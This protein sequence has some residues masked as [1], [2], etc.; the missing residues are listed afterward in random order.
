MLSIVAM[1]GDAKA[2]S[3]L[4]DALDG[5][6]NVTC[7]R[8]AAELAT[9]ATYAASDIV[10]LGIK[11]ATQPP[12][13]LT[14]REAIERRPA[15]RLF[16]AC[17]ADAADMRTLA[18]LRYLDVW[19]VVLPYCDSPPMTRRRLLDAAP[20]R[21]ADM[22]V[23]RIMCRHAPAWI[24]PLIEWCA[25]HDGIARPDVPSLATTCNM[26]RETLARLCHMRGVCPP[27]HIISWVLVVRAR[28]R[29]VTPRHTLA[30]IAHDLGLASA[31]SLANLIQRR[32]GQTATKVR[33]LTL[34][35]IAERAAQA[36]FGR[37]LGNWPL[38]LGPADDAGGH[39]A[40]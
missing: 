6:A 17:R 25:E 29:M 9:R 7:V 32:T 20:G 3:H 1:I 13:R 27:N 22:E 11:D 31:G 34:D 37:R 30:D 28:A 26:R 23:R 16:V 33:T 18:R 35:Q 21:L 24:R 8:D 19:D 40:R 38:A 12:V 2:L 14:V 15:T 10:V 36:M 39:T 4:H 5:Y